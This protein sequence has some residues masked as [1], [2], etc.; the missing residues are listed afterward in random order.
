MRGGNHGKIKIECT[1][2]PL[3]ADAL[4]M[5]RAV[6]DNKDVIYSGR[7]RRYVAEVIETFVPHLFKQK[8][9]ISISEFRRRFP[10]PVAKEL[11]GIARR[12]TTSTPQRSR[13]T[14]EQG[15]NA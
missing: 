4:V 14:T 11:P 5:L 13:P 9:G 1:V 8:F 6:N 2:D 15:V 7:V 12:M 3:I 10:S